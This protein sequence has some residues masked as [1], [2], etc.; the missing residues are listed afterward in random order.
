MSA[1]EA[2]EQSRRGDGQIMSKTKIVGYL[3]S[4]AGAALWLYGYFTTGTPPFIDWHASA[5]EWIAKY[6]PNA[7]SEIGMG[8]MFVAMIPMYWPAKR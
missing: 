4:T 7:E 8:L 3:I 2:E 1:R 6:L 5:P